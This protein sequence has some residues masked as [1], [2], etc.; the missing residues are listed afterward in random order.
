MLNK[1][2]TFTKFYYSNNNK[3]N[4]SKRYYSTNNEQFDLL[5]M[6]LK[7]NK[8]NPVKIFNDIHLD[9]TKKDIRDNTRNLSGIYLIFNKITGDYYI[10]S[11]ST[12]RFYSRFYSHVISFNG[13]K[14]VK[15]AI[16]KYKLKNFAF[17]V[18]ELFPEIVN[19][20]N[21]KKL[22]D[23][24][25]IYLKSLLPNYNILTEA[26]NTF[27]YKHT[28]ITRIKMRTNYSEERKLR[29]GNLNRNKILSEDVKNKL[30][31]KALMRSPRIFTEEALSNMKKNS[32]PVIL[33]NKD[34]TVYGEFASITSL[35]IHLNCSIKT[36][37]RALSSDSKLLKRRWIIKYKS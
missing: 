34:G 31:T 28:E 4:I 6:F 7:D 11:A 15:L 1:C 24:E 26:G 5:D 12:D 13:S 22:L 3:C 9:S 8:I 20:E 25:D 35:S 18:L 16:K 19:K 30:R 23:L 10:G 29:I 37:S 2:N 14:I 32:K 33:Y 36:I 21:N 27:G 17:L